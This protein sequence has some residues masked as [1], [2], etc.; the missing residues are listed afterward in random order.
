MLLFIIFG[1]VVCFGWTSEMT[2][3][4]CNM[5]APSDK[6]PTERGEKIQE[7][8]LLRRLWKKSSFLY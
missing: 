5:F 1:L 8:N 3:S 6:R 7:L 2:S 4:S